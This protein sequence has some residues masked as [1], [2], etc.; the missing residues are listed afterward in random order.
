MKIGF[1][2]KYKPPASRKQ[3][4][5]EGLGASSQFLFSQTKKVQIPVEFQEIDL[6][7]Y[8]RILRLPFSCYQR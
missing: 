6:A 7:L 3:Y 8:C 5:K 4:K 2:N 1:Q